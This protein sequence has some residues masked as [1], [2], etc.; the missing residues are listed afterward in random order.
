MLLITTEEVDGKDK[1][2][3]RWLLAARRENVFLKCRCR[4]EGKGG[5]ERVPL[6]VFA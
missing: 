1:V 3:V 4:G 5:F 6:K 2:V